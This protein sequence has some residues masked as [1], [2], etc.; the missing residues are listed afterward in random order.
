MLSRVTTACANYWLK[1]CR[2]GKM[3]AFDV[4]NLELRSILSLKQDTGHLAV[5]LKVYLSVFVKSGRVIWGFASVVV[6]REKC[7]SAERHWK[8]PLRHFCDENKPKT[9]TVWNT[10]L[11]ILYYITSV[12]INS[13]NLFVKQSCCF[14]YYFFSLEMCFIVENATLLKSHLKMFHIKFHKLVYVFF[15]SF[16]SKNL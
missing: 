1:G 13:V 10:M 4:L 9:C 11:T 3:N 15:I 5:Q 7:W 6:S 8:A 12:C 16:I 14:L 2:G